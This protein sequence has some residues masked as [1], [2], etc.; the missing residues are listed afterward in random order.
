MGRLMFL[1][2]VGKIDG[3]VPVGTIRGCPSGEIEGV[4][5]W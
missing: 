4:S 1:L 3:G 5:Q 2:I